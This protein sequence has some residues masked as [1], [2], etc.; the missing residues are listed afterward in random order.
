M[1]QSSGEAINLNIKTEGL[2]TLVDSSAIS[3][4]LSKEQIAAEYQG[5]SAKTGETKRQGCTLPKINVRTE[6]SK[7]YKTNLVLS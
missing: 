4:K 7:A 5:K 6:I 3:D 1:L 2:H